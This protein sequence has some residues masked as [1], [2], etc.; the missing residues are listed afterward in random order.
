M[1]N[2]ATEENKRK[3][4]NRTL[5][6]VQPTDANIDG[7]TPRWVAV[8][9]VFFIFFVFVVGGCICLPQIGIIAIWRQRRKEKQD[10]RILA[11]LFRSDTK[12]A[13]PSSIQGDSTSEQDPEAAVAPK[14]VSTKVGNV[15]STPH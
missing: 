14:I 15:A 2:E 7:S 8:V 13:P 6:Y 12:T 10:E 5:Y 3:M 1:G 9:I 11:D 4:D